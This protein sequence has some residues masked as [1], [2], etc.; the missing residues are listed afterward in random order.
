[1]RRKEACACAQPSRSEIVQTGC[2]DQRR[3]GPLSEWTSGSTLARTAPF[4]PSG[5]A[6]SGQIFATGSSVL[7]GVSWWREG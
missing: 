4:P 5:N 2:V 6:S 3:S 1:M 7:E